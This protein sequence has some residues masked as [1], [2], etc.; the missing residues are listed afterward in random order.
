MTEEHGL[1]ANLRGAKHDTF[2]RWPDGWTP[3]KIATAV[4]R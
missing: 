1:G 4:Q 3:E 2:T